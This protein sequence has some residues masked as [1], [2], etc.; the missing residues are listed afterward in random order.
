MFIYYI[1]YNS[2]K[3][4]DINKLIS[5]FDIALRSNPP[6]G[7]FERERTRGYLW[8]YVHRYPNYSRQSRSRLSLSSRPL[9]GIEPATSGQ[10]ANCYSIN[11][12]HS[13]MGQD[14]YSVFWLIKIDNNIVNITQS[15]NDC[16]IVP[17]TWSKCWMIDCVFS[18]ED[19]I[20]GISYEYESNIY[21]PYNVFLIKP[22]FNYQTEIYNKGIIIF[23][24]V[25]LFTISIIMITI[26]LYMII[27]TKNILE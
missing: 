25:G 21:N 13:D 11:V 26:G 3:I 9:S 19:P 15:Y 20:C 12:I 17:N 8:T 6:I 14:N 16:Q 18:E 1:L 5:H 10:L 24:Y 7:G 27:S 2:F 23:I 22:A 4:S